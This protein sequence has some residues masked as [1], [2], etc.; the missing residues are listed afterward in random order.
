MPPTLT[1][2]PSVTPEAM[3][4]LPRQILLPQNDQ[5]RGRHEQKN[6]ERNQEHECQLSVGGEREERQKNHC[7]RRIPC[8]ALFVVPAGRPGNRRSACRRCS[9]PGRSP[10]P[11]FPRRR[12]L[13]AIHEVKRQERVE[14]VKDDRAADRRTERMPKPRQSSSPAKLG[15]PP[16]AVRR[17]AGCCPSIARSGPRPSRWEPAVRAAPVIPQET[18]TAVVITGARANP[19]P[20][21]TEK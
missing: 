3:P 20:P 9:C 18:T 13:P 5:N 8:E 2:R 12:L 11:G 7:P 17:L 21:P 15:P 19:S 4:T 6:G 1:A 16:D 14:A 10:A